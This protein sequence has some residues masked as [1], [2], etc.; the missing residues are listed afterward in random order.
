MVCL[1]NS[2]DPYFK[3]IDLESK[4][5]LYKSPTIQK[6]LNPSWPK[7]TDASFVARTDSKLIVQFFDRDLIGNGE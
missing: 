4:K 5:T 7:L 3:I 6:S 1:G 2:S